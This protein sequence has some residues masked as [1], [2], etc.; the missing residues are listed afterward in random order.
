[1]PLFITRLSIFYFLLPWQVM[2]F[3]NKEQID[4][5][6]N[7]YYH[8]SGGVPELLNTVV[9]VAAILLLVL[10]VIGFKKRITY[11]LVLIFHFGAVLM[12]AQAYIWGLDS[13]RLIFLAALPAASAIWLL[14]LLRDQDT[15]LTIGK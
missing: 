14:W 13:F 11:L 5:I 3:T 2:R 10:F 7:T 1:L 4:N 6:A 15:L 9:G 8:Q 12:S